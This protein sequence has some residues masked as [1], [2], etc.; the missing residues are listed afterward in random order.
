LDATTALTVIGGSFASSFTWTYNVTANTYQG[1]QNQTI[2]GLDLVNFTNEGLITIQYKVTQ[3][4]PQDALNGFTVN[5]TPPSY[6]NISNSTGD[7]QVSSYTFTTEGKPTPVITWTYPADIIYGTLLSSLQL[8]ATVDQ[9]PGTFVYTPAAGTLL[10]VG[11]DQVLAVVFTP[12]DGAIDPLPAWVKINV[13]RKPIT[14]TADPGLKK[15]YGTADPIFTFTHTPDLIG[16]D[17]FSGAL[18]RAPGEN[19]GLYPILQGTLSLGNNY[20]ITFI[21]NDFEITHKA[22]IYVTVTASPGKVYGE[23]D[24]LF[25]YSWYPPLEEGDFFTGRLSRAPGENVGGYLINRGT[26]TLHPKYAITVAPSYLMITPKPITV[27]AV[28]GSKVYDGTTASV[29]KPAIS[30]DLAFADASEFIQTYDTKNTG[31]GKTMS[32]SGMVNDSNGEKNYTV[33]FADNNSGIIIPKPLTGSIT[34]AGKV[35]DGTIA[36]TIL[37]RALNGVIQGDDVIYTGGTATFDTPTVGTAKTVTATGFSLSGADAGNYTVSNVT[38]TTA[39]I[40]VLEAGTSLTVNASTFTHYSD[41]ITLTAIVYGG[42]PLAGGPQAAA[43]ATF[44]IEGRVIRDNSNNADI[45]LTV[46]GTNLVATITVSILETTTIGSLAA[47]THEVTAD[48]NKENINYKVVPNPA[49]ASFDFSPGYTILVYPNPSPGQ[50]YFKISVDIGV[51]ELAT[52][53]LYA[54]N[55]QLVERLFD[56][57][58]R[59]GEAKTIPFASRLAQGIYLYRAQIGK[60][61]KVGNVII[62]GVY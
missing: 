28:A 35:Y 25:D 40:F 14:V 3:N 52:L 27:T 49:K 6:T 33:T 45:P 24:P 61:V 17:S 54:P 50:I 10:N 42:A 53:D 29:G 7:D 55:G 36:A 57:F 30:P 4:S 34:A 47:G 20:S 51:G 48:F 23:A 39:D 18:T 2:P 43:S 59:V 62:I 12:A 5:L 41:Q 9:V 46:S 8:N 32:P 31:T 58:I 44:S 11:P 13:L 37:T 16:G 26:L 38:T 1:R 15:V 22:L 21:S 60:E 19:P 56:G